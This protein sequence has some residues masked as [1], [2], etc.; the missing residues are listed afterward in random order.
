MLVPSIGALDAFLSELVIELMPKLAASGSAHS[1]FSLIMRDNS[2]LVLQAVYLSPDDLQRALSD[3]IEG[4][5]QAK[6][7]HGSKAV[8]QAYDWCNLNLSHQDFD[9]QE[10]PQALGT[11]DEWTE[12]RHRIV[13]RGEL[14]RMRRD[15]AGD[16]IKLVRSIGKTLNDR[17]IARHF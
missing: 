3:A 8:R 17:A 12:K 13:H 6:V 1:I 4:Y 11:L 16:V 5:F 9:S 14:V 7:M 2:G 15:D 10:F